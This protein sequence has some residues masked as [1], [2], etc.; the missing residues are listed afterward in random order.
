MNFIVKLFY[1]AFALVGILC[2]PFIISGLFFL[3][4][5]YKR[6]Q[7]IPIRRYPSKW[8]QHSLLRKLVIDFPCAFVHD[9][10]HRNPDA[11]PMSETG[12][13]IFEGE[14]GSGKTVSAV[15]YMDMLR[16]KYPKLSIMSNVNLSFAD[17][18]LNDWQDIVFKSNG[19]YGQIVL[20]DE[21]QNY[22]NSLDSRN[23]PPEMIQEICQQRKQRKCIIGTVQVFNRVAKPI[24]E[25]TRYI[26]RPRT[27]FG[28]LT[29]MTIWKPHFD[30]NAQ[31][32][33][34][35]RVKTHIFVHTPFIREAYDTFETVELHALHGFK[36]RAEFLQSPDIL[37][38]SDKT[39]EKTKFKR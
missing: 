34:S 19:E 25:Q 28:C 15:W 35:Y 39:K 17:S 12:L 11:F 18:R 6:G 13:V 1:F 2:L 5:S 9:L 37:S 3:V 21:I 7:K 20:L 8:V 31:V 38:I 16:K 33:K 29:I 32:D 4:R 23:F 30:D 36:P 24:R 27:L 14:Q 22:F 10:I 26:V